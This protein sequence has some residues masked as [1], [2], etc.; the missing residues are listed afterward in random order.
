MQREGADPSRSFSRGQDVLSPAPYSTTTVD[1]ILHCPQ[2]GFDNPP[3]M[4]F[5]GNCGAAL[6]A[7]P[8]AE[9]RKLVTVLFVDVVGSTK[10]SGGLDPERLHAMMTRFFAIAREEIERYGGTVEKFIGD[11]VMAVFGLPMI[12]EDDPERAAR[13]ATAIRDRM[14]PAV[15][16]GTLPPIRI[17]LNTGEVMANPR[18]FERGEFLVTGEMVNLAARLQQH[19]E[20]GQILIGERTMQ[21]IR[22][23]AYLVPIAPLT[24]KG[25][26]A[27]VPAWALQDVQPPRARELRATPF[28]GR[29]EEL[30]LLQGHLRR[31]VREGRGHVV[32]ILGPA[33]VG[34]TRL[35][36]EFRQRAEDVH[37]LSG[38][39]LPYGTGVPFWAL[40]EAIREHCGIRFGDPLNVAQQKLEDTAATLE[41]TDAVPALMSV[42]GLAGGRPDLTR[43]ALFAAMRD[44]FQAVALPAPLALVVEDVHL[45]EDVTL[46]F[47]E[48]AA[49]WIR[50]SPILLLVL[51]RPE[52]LERRGAW[53]GGK[54]GT[55][56]LALDP[57]GDAESRRL[58]AAILQDQ[59]A[60]DALLNR[61]LE[62]A[63]GNPLFME[64]MLRALIEQGVL[65]D[66]GQGWELTV[67]V[68]QV[69]IPD[70]VHAVIAARVDALLAPEKRLLQA[71]AVLGKDFWL[72]GVQFVAEPNTIEETVRTLVGKELLIHKRRSSVA[73][74]E[75][76]TFRH[77]LIRDVAYASIPK[78][79]RWQQHA[80]VAR[81]MAQIGGNRQREFADFIA[82]HW[83]QVVNLRQEL[84]LPPDAQA[85]QQAVDNL[86]LAGERAAAVYANTTALDHFTRA[87]D[88]DPETP[89]RHR[90]IEG[91]GKVWMLLG[92]FDRARED[93]A[94]LRTLA[95]QADDRRWQAVALDHIGHSYRR[96]DRVDLALQ[97]LHQAYELSR[98][99]DDSSLGGRILNHIGFTLFSDGQYEQARQAHDDARA[100]LEGAQDAAGLAESLHGLGDTLL[101][102]GAYRDSIASYLESI[103]ICDQIGNRALIGESRFMIGFNH[104][105]LGDFQKAGDEVEQSLRI[106]SEIGDVWNQPPALFTG[107]LTAIR[108]GNF[109]R[110]LEY[111]NRGLA[112]ARQLGVLRFTVFHLIALGQLYRELEDTTGAL[113]ADREAAEL[114]V[115]VGGA[116]MPLA[117]AGLAL[118]CARLGDFQQ[119]EQHL[120][121]ARNS[122]EVQLSLGDF[123]QE[124]HLA[125]ARVLH[126]SGKHAQAIETCTRLLAL[127]EHTGTLHHWKAFTLL[128]QADAMMAL[129]NA[130]SALALCREAAVEAEQV[131]QKPVLWRILAGAAESLRALGDRDEAAAIARR[132]HEI[133]DQLAAKVPDERLRATFLQSA[134][135]QRVTTLS[136]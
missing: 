108:I 130:P 73:G 127:A 76:F 37:A 97:H 81:W 124:V 13:A 99:I 129:G 48:H 122:R 46:D 80:R 78:S 101:F 110:A 132:A 44:F 57:L 58:S 26:A 19:A 11:A 79:Q 56:T 94:A 128:V 64:E 135:V 5:C 33:G 39:A 125:E 21:A 28:V 22:Q 50:D 10:L 107:G 131:G 40:G 38:R 61:V 34:K 112:L 45:A 9:E 36:R 12:H 43:E 123:P 27:P 118:D 6:T 133:V 134:R 32:T 77:I 8:T 119:A 20:A 89:V 114:A 82:H 25:A 55:T 17:G 111:L 14:R 103:R 66:R 1:E 60:P 2:C 85:R 51:A 109:G 117:Q 7:A 91:R 18:A 59:P 121:E 52:L 87:L 126:L 65:L 105:K 16:A 74:E 92:Q 86:V 31:M 96:Q 70:T 115:R 93:F 47:L 4:R 95:E 84:G 68:A 106:T 42:L 3:R 30:A 100:L 69:M 23:I 24:V 72:N 120:A 75:E 35:A 54:R 90:L 71:A 53:M 98:E 41:V 29:E 67:P 83:L 88:L 116:W 113:Q 136:G 15:E 102:L 63:E 49:D 104:E 62:R